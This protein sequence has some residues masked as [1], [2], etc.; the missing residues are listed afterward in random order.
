[1]H[2][3]LTTHAQE[4][5]HRY[6]LQVYNR[7]PIT[8]Q[9]AQGALIWDEMGKEY[10]DL[11]AGIAVNNVGHAHP[12]LVKAIQKAAAE[13]LHLSNFYYTVSQSQ[14][15]E[16]LAESTGLD[17]VFFCNSGAETME[18][19][20]KLARKWG[21]KHDKKGDIVSLS[22]GFHGRTM[23]TITMSSHKYQKG[24]DPLPSG[25]TQAG[26]NNIESVRSVI[27]SDTIAIAFELIQGNSGVH[28]AHVDF[29]QEIQRLC[30]ENNILLIIDEVQTGI[31]RTGTMWCYEH[32]HLQPDIVA[33]A[34]ALAG[35]IPI[36]AMMAKEEVA[37]CMDAGDH[38]T[39]FGGNPFAC[40]VAL[41]NLA[42]IEEESLMD[43]AA[44]KGAYFMDQ[45]QQLSKVHSCIKQVRGKGLMIG[46]ELDRP[47]APLVNEWAKKGVLS[48]SAGGNAFRIVPPL[49][50]PNRLID[51]AIEQL[52]TVLKD[53]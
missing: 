15:A 11:L 8:I 6:H 49:N 45:L 42:I 1:M 47:T 24:Y 22:N 29:V 14:L 37:H 41:E 28:P 23:S 7:L 16:K 13:P 39:T 3:S 51:Q 31:G 4:L 40:S 34:K 5:E 2:S 38:G 26:F 35:G 9:R 27:N 50:I 43:E 17:R 25:F 19:C 12:R 36:G 48:N 33:S 18:S 20:I 46:L 53:L 30:S 32:Y 52:D 21:V 10:I 44:N